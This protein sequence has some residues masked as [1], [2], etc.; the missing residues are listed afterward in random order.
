MKKTT[1]RKEKLQVVPFDEKKQ[2]IANEIEPFYVST[3]KLKVRLFEWKDGKVSK[4][5][6]EWIWK[7]WKE[8]TDM[9]IISFE[10]KNWGNEIKQKNQYYYHIN[11]KIPK[12]PI[13]TQKYIFHYTYFILFSKWFFE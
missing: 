4:E 8:P 12:F 6:N 1:K 7:H 3:E 13:F 5:I 9:L 10:K 2:K 11:S